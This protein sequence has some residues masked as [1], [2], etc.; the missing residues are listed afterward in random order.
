ML[1]KR[2][3]IYHGQRQIWYTSNEIVSL[4]LNPYLPG[5]SKTTSFRIPLRTTHSYTRGSD[6]DT[7]ILLKSEKLRTGLL[8][9]K[10]K[11]I[12]TM[13][14]IHLR[15]VFSK[16]GL[17]LLPITKSTWHLLSPLLSDTHPIQFYAKSKAP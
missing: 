4:I 2:R 9:P 7:Q 5:L 12:L 8:K 10:T 15:R 13:L 3:R 17:Q 16:S 6:L 14:P 1:A 11:P